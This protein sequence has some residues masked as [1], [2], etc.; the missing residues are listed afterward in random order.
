MGQRRKAAERRG[1]A[2]QNVEPAEPF[3]D[4][5]GHFVDPV[6]IAQVDGDQGRLG[7]LGRGRDPVVDLFER[8]GRPRRQDKAGAFGGEPLR[9][10]GADAARRAGD[11]RNPARQ[12][13]HGLRYP[14]RAARVRCRS[15]RPR[16]R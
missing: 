2:D 16:S 5:P 1:V 10:S 12:G 7:A 15:S 8:A 11:Q 4:R 6:V 3:G 13:A 14:L 9:H